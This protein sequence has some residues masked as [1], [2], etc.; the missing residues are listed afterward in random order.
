VQEGKADRISDLLEEA[1]E[2]IYRLETLTVELD[3]NIDRLQRR[4]AGYDY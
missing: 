1:A 4:L 2:E 3:D